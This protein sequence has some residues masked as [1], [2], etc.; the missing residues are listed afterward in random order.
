MTGKPLLFRVVSHIVLLLLLPLFP[1][2]LLLEDETITT[3][4]VGE[5]DILDGEELLL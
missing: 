1:C 2:W 4:E 3:G 5:L